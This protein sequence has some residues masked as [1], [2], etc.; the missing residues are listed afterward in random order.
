MLPRIITF[1]ERAGMAE[2]DTDRK[3]RQLDHDVHAIY[4]ILESISA[5]QQE[6]GA[7]LRKADA[8]ADRLGAKLDRLLDRLGLMTAAGDD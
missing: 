2:L 3:V 4:E 7:A 1:W 8:K 6:H 5:A